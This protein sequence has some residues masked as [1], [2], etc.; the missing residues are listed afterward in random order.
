MTPP[1]ERIGFIGLGN[2]GRPMASSLLRNGFAVTAFDTAAM[3]IDR[4]VERGG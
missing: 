4:L 2:M 1:R 3:Q